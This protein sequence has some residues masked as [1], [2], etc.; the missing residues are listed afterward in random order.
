[1]NPDVATR[2]AHLAEHPWLWR[3]GW[4]PWQIT[5]ASD[6]LLSVAL[7]RTR[8]IPR[9]P[10]LVAVVA[11]LAAIVPDQTGQWSWTWRGVSLADAAVTSGDIDSY[12]LY[13]AAIFRRIAGWAAIGYLMGALG[14]TWAFSAAG[15]WSGRLTGLSIAV[16]TLFALATSTV[17]LPDHLRALPGMS[18]AVSV[19]NAFAFL[20]LMWW[21]IEVSEGVFRRDQ[22]RAS[23]G[24]T[25]L[26]RHPKSG[27]VPRMSDAL[28]NSAFTRAITAPIPPLAMASDITDVVYVNYLVDAGALVPLVPAP[29]QLQR[30]GPSGRYA[31]FTFLTFRHGH[32]GPSCFGALRRV[33]PSPLQSN[34]RLYV[35]NPRTGTRGVQFLT[36]A[37]TS[38][39]HALAARLLAEGVPMHVPARAH[40]RRDVLGAVDLL[41]ESGAGTAPDA[42]ATLVPAPEPRLGSP[43]DE[44]FASWREFLAYCVP[45]DRA[46]CVSRTT[47]R[48]LRQEIELDIPLDACH[49]L[50]GAVVSAAAS[51]IAGNAPPLSFVVDRVGFRF[52]SQAFD[53]T[54]LAEHAD[55]NRVGDDDPRPAVSHAVAAPEVDPGHARRGG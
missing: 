9:F 54:E 15:T 40:L 43:W 14:W 50:S 51:A 20:L 21:L 29:L 13:E 33:W 41:L 6:L 3:L 45:Q 35:V 38:T 5:A 27:L 16:W 52:A 53:E 28:A 32:F 30:L 47:G 37:I 24:A 7:L 17:F 36:T 18:R 12:A 4:V 26:W 49:P 48:V 11:T 2:A 39:P 46:M 22:P 25:A 42:R 19:G 55:G 23:H 31:L 44:C 10:A 1:M 34:W 8:W